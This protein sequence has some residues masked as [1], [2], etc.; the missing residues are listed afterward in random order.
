MCRGL[1][2]LGCLPQQ[3]R[4]YRKRPTQLGTCIMCNTSIPF[5]VAMSFENRGSECRAIQ[6]EVL[7]LN[8]HEFYAAPEEK[9]YHS[10]AVW[11]KIPLKYADADY[12]GLRCDTRILHVL[13]ILVIRTCRYFNADNDACLISV[14]SNGW[15]P[16]PH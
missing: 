15:N 14:C 12:N 13:V 10:D 9:K 2:L 4:S 3:F 11:L 5:L 7:I 6:L 8:R 16:Q 1:P